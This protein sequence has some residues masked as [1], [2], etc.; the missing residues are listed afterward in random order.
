MGHNSSAC[1]VI[2]LWPLVILVQV[3]KVPEEFVYMV[4]VWTVTIADEMHFF[5]KLQC[6]DDA[7]KTVLDTSDTLALHT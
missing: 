7:E 6:K 5:H 4:A 3:K 1:H 2:Y